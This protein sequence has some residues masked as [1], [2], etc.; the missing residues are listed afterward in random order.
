MILLGVY[1]RAEARTLQKKDVRQGLNNSSRF[2]TAEAVPFVRSFSPTGEARTYLL[3]YSPLS[4]S[5][6]CQGRPKGIGASDEER[7]ISILACISP[8]EMSVDD[9]HLSTNKSREVE[10]PGIY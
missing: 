7:L 1:V 3:V 9:V 4:F 10:A 8:P 2:G 5:A 6:A